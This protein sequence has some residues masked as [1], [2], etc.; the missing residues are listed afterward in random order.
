MEDGMYNIKG[1][2][3]REREVPS[4]EEIASDGA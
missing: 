1:E 3:E 4:V 2:R